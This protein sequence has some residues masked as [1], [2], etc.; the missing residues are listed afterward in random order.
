MLDERAVAVDDDLELA[1]GR[2][3]HVICEVPY[4]DRVKLA[5]AV[6]RGHV[7][8]RLRVDRSRENDRSGDP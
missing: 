6:R 5:I 2:F 3:L 7:P 4:V 8:P 1:A